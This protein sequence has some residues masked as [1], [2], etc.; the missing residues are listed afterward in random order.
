MRLRSKELRHSESQSITSTL[1]T[2]LASFATVGAATDFLKDS[3]DGMVQ[4][5]RGRTERSITFKH[6]SDTIVLKGRDEIEALISLLQR[7]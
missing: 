2:L 7:M 5:Q 1:H 6:K 4:W 3:C